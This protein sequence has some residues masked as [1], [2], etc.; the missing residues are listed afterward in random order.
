M[1]TIE[2]TKEEMQA[3]HHERFHHPHPP[4]SVKNASHMAQE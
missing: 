1:I 2:F 4:Y 3:L